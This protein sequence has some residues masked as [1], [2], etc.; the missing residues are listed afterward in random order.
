MP[1]SR[2]VNQP[3]LCSPRTRANGGVNPITGRAYDP[4]VE[5]Q[6][7]NKEKSMRNRQLQRDTTGEK[8]REEMG[9]ILTG[10]AG[11]APNWLPSTKRVASVQKTQLDGGDRSAHFTQSKRVFAQANKTSDW[12][13]GPAVAPRSGSNY[14]PVDTG[15]TVIFGGGK[16]S[17][18][19]GPRG[20][21]FNAKKE[22]AARPGFFKNSANMGRF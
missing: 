18:V 12:N 16:K 4:N 5:R 2:R 7:E 14:K 15:V 11:M 13:N 22:G 8:T 9:G 10:R 21:G 1:V 19:L 3:A 6:R 17:N 20:G